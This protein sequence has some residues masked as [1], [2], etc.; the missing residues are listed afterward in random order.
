MITG[1][2]TDVRHGTTVYHVQTEDKGRN[3]PKIETLVYV[4]GEILDNHRTAYDQD[5]QSLGEEEIMGLMES[6]HKRVIRSI[7]TGKYDEPEGFPE[8][9]VTGRGFD[10]VVAEYL[11]SEAVS[12]YLLMAVSGHEALRSGPTA[13][14]QIT[15]LKAVS[16]EPAVGADIRIKLVHRQHK[17]IIMAEDISGENGLVVTKIKLPDWGNEGT[18]VVQA[19]SEWGT[20]SQRIPLGT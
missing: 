13:T 18:L 6:Q 8:G 20:A 17:V 10:E 5:K 15:T 1:F 4:G 7:K 9:V 3:N 16:K 12:D 2:N 19:L 14:L 11:G